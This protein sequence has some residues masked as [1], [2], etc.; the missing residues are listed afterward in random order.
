[1]FQ[2]LKNFCELK[3]NLAFNLITRTRQYV[4]ND[5]TVAQTVSIQRNGV[6][7]TL[8]FKR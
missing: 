5:S 7:I 4:F 8:T 2:K 6:L 3:L 1:M